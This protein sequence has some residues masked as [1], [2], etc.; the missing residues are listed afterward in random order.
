MCLLVSLLTDYDI[1]DNLSY[2]SCWPFMK[3]KD[4]SICGNVISGGEGYIVS[5]EMILQLSSSV[6]KQDR[7]GL[8]LSL[9]PVTSLPNQCDPHSTLISGITL[10]TNFKPFQEFNS[11]IISFWKQGQHF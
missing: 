1:S 8:I 4:C 6:C 2:V 3:F 7:I 11:A 9:C 5:F 10:G